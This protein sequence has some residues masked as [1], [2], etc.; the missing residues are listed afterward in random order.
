[1]RQFKE[2]QTN[3]LTRCS[4]DVSRRNVIDDGEQE[5]NNQRPY[6]KVGFKTL[7][8]VEGEERDVRLPLVN[9]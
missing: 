1:V 2:A 5:R 4:E 6:G 7:R 8:R 3:L 9:R